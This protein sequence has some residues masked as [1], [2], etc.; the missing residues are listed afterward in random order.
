M[1]FTKYI[2]LIFIIPIYCQF[3]KNIVQYKSFDWH[4]IQSK[5]FDIY[6]YDSNNNLTNINNNAEFVASESLKSY[7]IISNAIGW[8]LKNRIPII[9]Y[10]SHNDFQQ[11][12]IIDMYMPEG[13]GGVTEL[14]KNRVVIP[15]DGNNQQ[16]KNVI[17]HELV[18]A[19]INDYIYKGSVKNMQ[20]D[21]VILIP[22]WMNEGLA[23]FLSSPWQTDSDMWMRDLV[24]NGEKLPKLN[25]LNGYLAYRGGQS[26]WKYI[27]EEL[28]TLYIQ[29]KTEAPTIISSI[30]SAIAT[31]PDL[32]TALEKSL[33][34]DL[35]D[36]ESGW[37]KYLKSEYWPDINNRNYLNDISFSLF[38]YDKISST[39]D[40]GPSLSPDKTKL[41]FYSNQ[42]GIMSLCI[43]PSD[44]NNC[45]SKS[46]KTILKSGMS[47]DFEELHVLK[48][49]ISWSPNSENIIIGSSSKGKDLL[50][51]ININSNKKQKH[52]FNKFNFG[53]I[54]QPIWH[55]EEENIIAFIATNISQGDIYLYNLDTQKIT[56]LTDDI[57][58][59]KEIAWT[60]DGQSILF[61]ADR[62]TNQNES[63]SSQYDLFS[64]NIQNEQII[65]LTNTDFNEHY[66]ISTNNDSTL[67]YISDSNGINNLSV[68]NIADSS[69]NVFTNLY[70]GISQ[71]TAIDDEIYFSSLNDR[72]FIISKLDS[73]INLNNQLDIKNAKWKAKKINYDFTKLKNKFDKKRHSYRNYIFDQN[74]SAANS[75]LKSDS[76]IL[77]KID[78]SGNYVIEKYKTKFS[79]DVGQ[80]SVGVGLNARNN[81]Y[82]QNG[83]AVFQFS[84]ILGDHK[85]YLGTEL[86]VNFKRSD[87]ALVYRYLPKLIDWTFMFSH[88][89]FTIRENSYIDPNGNLLENQTL[90]ENISLGID[91][92]RPLSRFNRIEFNLSQFFMLVHDEV[93][94]GSSQYGGVENSD[95]VYSGN[96]TT[97]SSRYVWDNTRWFYT[98]PNNGS[99]FY[100]KYKTDPRTSK[101]INLLSFDGR[102]Y[103]PLFNGVSI[104]LRNFLGH[105]WGDDRQSIYLGSEPSIYSSTPGI[106]DFYLSEFSSSNSN[107]LTL[108]NF[109]ENITPIRGVPFMYKS[110]D[111]LALFNF[112]LRA[113]FLLYYFPAIKWFGQINGV[114]FIDLGVAWNNNEPLP[115]ISN[116]SNWIKREEAPNKR[117]GW[118]MSY[119]WGPRFIFLGMPLKLNFAWQYNPIT[120]EKSDRRYEIT[121]G[122]DL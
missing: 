75:D 34:L 10:N 57:F 25:E 106:S 17:H 2:F 116:Q 82:T 12:N 19:F 45:N 31:S 97:F 91:A 118:V 59:E 20:N 102:V 48:A 80:L 35:E 5:Y 113:P 73:N 94:N 92:N 114:I 43:V 122:I 60:N 110:G 13:V 67:L 109:T 69:I 93:I 65:Q 63:W 77:S 85:I 81:N 90:Y 70:T 84:D 36:L 38:D 117:T 7:D 47:I 46:I 22:L 101:D 49:G 8:K 24:V 15:F 9:V 32:N 121:I 88:D 72:K 100:F 86:D 62:T 37:H 83:L 42:N 21:D 54:S 104:F 76:L 26:V 64:Y 50:Y 119:G 55:P 28:D 27:I 16:F 71:I 111:N 115:N 14:Y 95:L 68:K 4:Y 105:T 41:A 108:F 6:F 58:T 51:T 53:S 87:Y 98:Y 107:L 61:S 23:E 30:F 33:N 74:L 103:R 99:R 11:T 44:C 1:K 39:Y 66:P 29:G 112:E 18:H 3:G 56:Q 89:G 120:K 78:S 52:E 96:L 79:L 40:I